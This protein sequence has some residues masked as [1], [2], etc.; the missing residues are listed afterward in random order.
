[1]KVQQLFHADDGG[2][3]GDDGYD[4][5]DDDR[6]DDRDDDKYDDRDEK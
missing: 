1:M 3:Y 6:Y 4:D 5:R 2:E